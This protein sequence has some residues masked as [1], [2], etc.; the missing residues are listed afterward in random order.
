MKYSKDKK[1]SFDSEKHVYTKKDKNLVSVTTLIS[2]F[3][4]EFDSNFY[5]ERIA[6][7]EGVTQKEILERWSLKAKKSCEIGTAIHKI[8]ED[9]ANNDYF[10]INGELSFDFMEL[11]EDYLLDFESK[12]KSCFKFIKEIFQSKRLTPV[13]VEH[14]VYNDFLAGQI[15]MICKDQN[16][17]YYILDFKTNE[18]IEE[19]S[20]G[21]KMKGELNDIDDSSFYHYSLQLSIYKQ[22]FIEKNIK[23]L[24][25]IHIKP[26][27]YE[28]IGC[29]DI[30]ELKSIDL[31]TLY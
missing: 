29:K 26:D 6:K 8:F 27:G 16:D 30:L 2:K 18:K 23:G 24:Y 31:K 7:K 25:L 1:V 13:Y 15:D 11:Q 12:K 17:S 21:K 28:I 3:K 14:I 5:S 9:Y 10:L 20:Y 19:F 22:M 4:N